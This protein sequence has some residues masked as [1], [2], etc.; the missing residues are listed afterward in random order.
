MSKQ[1]C[2]H[3]IGGG[4]AGLT[5]AWYLHRADI[6]FLLLEADSRVGGRVQTDEVNGFL[7]DRGFQVLLSEYPEV[8]S[9]LPP[10][11]LG[12]RAFRSG[13]EIQTPE[14]ILRLDNPFQHPTRVF[15]MLFSPIGSLMD[16]IRLYQLIR[17]VGTF[18][19]EKLLSQPGVSALEFLQ[20]RGFSSRIIDQFFKPFFG[21]V[22]LEFDLATS[23]RF[24]QFVFRQFFTG[25]AVLPAQGMGAI[26]H[27]LASQLPASSLALNQRIKAIQGKTITLASGEIIEAEQLV[28]ATDAAQA[29]QWL[30]I[31][32]DR[33]YVGTTCTYFST[34]LLP[35]TSDPL[36]RL[37]A[38]PTGKVRHW[39]VPSLVQ[40]A[41]AP[42]GKHL[43]SVTS[44]PGTPE[45]IRAEMKKIV[46][47]EVDAWEY[48][49]TYSIPHALSFFP[50][51]STAGALDMQPDVYR[52]GD[53]LL[54]PS[55]NAAMKS[56]RMVAEK[57]IQKI[58]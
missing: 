38:H 13:A 50:P 21:G 10:S 49:A 22:F 30:G 37:I 54:Y 18:Q 36:L 5:C 1:S 55:L 15:S 12:Y 25:Q 53:Y 33:T 28:V 4:V 42:A 43:I 32:A 52:C 26:P 58:R 9:I 56:G 46:G 24:F 11:V 27:Y 39:T 20:K 16:K 44:L 3:I 29:D 45:E 51:G 23:S 2:V 6:P 19:E 57:I 8:K 14:G 47:E 35:G 34:S 7:L 48:L 17:K 31:P 40:P 41:Y